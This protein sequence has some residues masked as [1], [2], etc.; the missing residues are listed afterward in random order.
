MTSQGIPG[1]ACA[2]DSCLAVMALNPQPMWI[3]DATMS[4]FLAANE[5]AVER[6]GYSREEFLAIKVDAIF[7]RANGSWRHHPKH[8]RSF[9]AAIRTGVVSFEDRDALL[10]HVEDLSARRMEELLSASYTLGRM[11]AQD[12]DDVVPGA[13]SCLCKSLEFVAAELWMLDDD[14][15]LSCK[16]AW[17]QPGLPE[18]ITAAAGA[19]I[20]VDTPESILTW[21]LTDHKP[22]WTRG[23]STKPGFAERSAQL[24]NAGIVRRCLMYRVMVSRDSLRSSGVTKSQTGLPMISEALSPRS[25]HSAL[26]TR[27][28]MPFWSASW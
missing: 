27:T 28:M 18:S 7:S 1:N 9:E 2:F 16:A 5:A 12:L 10:V 11:F 19:R 14:E 26:F 22:C 4:R 3:C 21:V 8:G 23:I 6:Y 20:A 25:W 13:L 15:F 24:E 17:R